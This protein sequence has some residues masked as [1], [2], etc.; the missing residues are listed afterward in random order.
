[1]P[2]LKLDHAIDLLSVTSQPPRPV[3]NFYKF[4][5]R[6]NVLF[7]TLQIMVH[8][9]QQKIN[10]LHQQHQPKVISHPQHQRQPQQQQMLG[11]LLI[12]AA[13]QKTRK[14][15]QC[16]ECPN[17][18]HSTN[19]NKYYSRV[20]GCISKCLHSTGIV[21]FAMH[22]VCVLLW[23]VQLAVDLMKQFYKLGLTTVNIPCHGNCIRFDPVV[24]FPGMC[25]SVYV[26]VCI[27]VCVCVCVC[28]CMCVCKILSFQLMY[29]IQRESLVGRIFDKF[30]LFKCLAEKV[31]QMNRLAKG[32]LIVITNL[33]GFSLANRR[34]FA[35]KLSTHQTFYPPN[36]PTIQ[37]VV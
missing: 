6:I 11:T 32:L 12:T 8:H 34:R 13:L 19:K 27:C 29:H 20:A 23:L 1:M 33:D 7:K 5:S 3:R 4:G 9:L 36:F 10:L 18:G 28:A 35:T 16:C 21:E 2:S 25:V 24:S 30:I 15:C 17:N 22:C 26:S 14:C 31:W 37:Y